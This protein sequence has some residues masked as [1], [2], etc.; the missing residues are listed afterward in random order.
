MILLR[1]FFTPEIGEMAL[2]VERA[3]WFVV[4]IRVLAHV[5]LAVAP[6]VLIVLAEMFVPSLLGYLD[7]G[8]GIRA[9][10]RLVMSLYYFFLWFFVFYEWLDYYLDVWIVTNHRIIE[11]TQRGFFNHELSELHLNRI[12]DMTLITKGFFSTFLDFG[13]VHIQ[14]AGAVERVIFKNMAKPRQFME[15]INGLM[16]EAKKLQPL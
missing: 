5:I 4:V 3:H 11:V 15:Q 9:M 1:R 16:V 10:V 14:T 8:N 13:D 2:R 7:N 6:V 12:Q